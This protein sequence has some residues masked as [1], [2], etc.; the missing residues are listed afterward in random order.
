MTDLGAHLMM[1]IPVM[2]IPERSYLEGISRDHLYGGPW[3]MWPDTTW[4][5]GPSCRPTRR[6]PGSSHMFRCDL[7]PQSQEELSSP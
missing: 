4:E 1:L 5:V 2:L 7:W 3:V 6:A